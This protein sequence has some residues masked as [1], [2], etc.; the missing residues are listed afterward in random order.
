MI[1]EE[2]LAAAKAAPTIERTVKISLPVGD[3]AD[4]I[5]LLAEL[6]GWR[7]ACDAPARL[8]LQAVADVVHVSSDDPGLDR[9]LERAGLDRLV[10][11]LQLGALE[12]LMVVAG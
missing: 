1:F 4:M 5:G 7:Q 11:P 12:Q 6:L 3:D 10:R 2:Q 8:Q 9:L